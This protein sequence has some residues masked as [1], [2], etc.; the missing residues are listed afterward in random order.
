MPLLVTGFAAARLPDL[1]LVRPFERTSFLSGTLSCTLSYCARLCQPE[2]MLHAPF[3][4]LP[5]QVDTA[6]RQGDTFAP[7]D[8]AVNFGKVRV[9]NQVSQCFTSKVTL[10]LWT[11]STVSTSL[12]SKPI[13]ERSIA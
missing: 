8:N 13:S 12:A 7:E 1:A 11:V 2:N 3:P 6:D 4:F 5:L 9:F 10:P